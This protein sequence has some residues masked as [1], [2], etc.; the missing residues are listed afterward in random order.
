M[1]IVNSSRKKEW[2]R[3]VSTVDTVEL[4]ENEVRKVV[5][6][7]FFMKCPKTVIVWIERLLYKKRSRSSTSKFQ[8]CF[9][10][11]V[12]AHSYM[13]LYTTLNNI[14]LTDKHMPILLRKTSKEPLTISLPIGFV[15]ITVCCD[16][17]LTSLWSVEYYV[18]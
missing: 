9:Y 10:Q 5:D 18:L 16:L 14:L 13:S 11:I 2:L 12:S 7:C 4:Q 15:I 3:Y 8:F 6:F 17:V 1:H